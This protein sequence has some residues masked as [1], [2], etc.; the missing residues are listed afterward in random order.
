MDALILAVVACGVAAGII[1]GLMPG[2]PAWIVPMLIIPVMPVLEPQHVIVFWLVTM[3]GSQFFGSIASIMFRIPGEQSS[4]VYLSDIQQAS[5]AQ[6]R[7][8]TKH[9]ADASIVATLLALVLIMLGQDVFLWV[10]PWLGTTSA[11]FAIL[12]GMMII[13]VMATGNRTV[14]A[15]LFLLGMVLAPK[16]NIDLPA[17]V[18]MINQ[19]T[20]D[21]SII[22]LLIGLMILPR[23]WQRDNEQPGHHL[24]DL[25]HIT[26]SNHR[27][28]LLGTG[29]GMLIGLLPGATATMSSVL[30][31]RHTPGNVWQR[32]VSAE[33]ANNSA[34]IIGAFLLIYL[35]L[36]LNLDSIVI[37]HVFNTQGWDFARDFVEAGKLPGTMIVVSVS[38][39]LIWF[40]ARRCRYLFELI[41]V[42]INDRW[43]AMM[44]VIVMFSVDIMTSHDSY[45]LTFYLGWLSA[46]TLLG[47]WCAKKNWPV[48][49][50]VLGYVIGDQLVWTTWQ[51]IGTL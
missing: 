8:L 6:R 15:A 19:V 34:I 9:T 10:L 28:S 42:R 26:D 48:F 37:N 5:P 21:L 18:L 38:A 27:S 1:A 22:S 39:V 2:L 20:Y 35:Q 50:A 11:T 51:M 29:V 23:L 46:V 4:L 40:L 14:S 13:T 12:I 33:A 36:P 47:A 49:P 17:G 16:S 31:Y 45:V 32:I 24:Q 43:F 44:V 3:I 30:A 25:P 7:D 41:A